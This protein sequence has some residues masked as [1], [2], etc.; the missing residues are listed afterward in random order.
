M[1]KLKIIKK[2]GMGSII[3]KMELFTKEDGSMINSME[4]GSFS[5]PMDQNLQDDGIKAWVQGTK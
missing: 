2:M 5:T 3:E 1:Q 4:K